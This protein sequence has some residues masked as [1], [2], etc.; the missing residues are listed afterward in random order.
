VASLTIGERHRTYFRKM[1]L[2]TDL[3]MFANLKWRRFQTN[4]ITM[5]SNL[6]THKMSHLWIH[7]IGG[8]IHH[9]HRRR[10]NY[11]RMDT[12]HLAV[13]YP[14]Q[15]LDSTSVGHA[16]LRCPLVLEPP[17]FYLSSIHCTIYR[18]Y[19]LHSRANINSGK[20]NM[21]CD[22][23]RHRMPVPTHTA[24]NPLTRRVVALIQT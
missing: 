1:V 2:L 24:L 6:R 12:K 5:L 23:Y 13:P 19:C 9:R 11:Y 18:T 16:S 8:R 7:Q 3:P 21:L 10:C 17:A 4:L 15:V 22:P 14:Q 20:F